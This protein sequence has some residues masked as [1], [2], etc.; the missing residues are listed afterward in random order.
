MADTTAPVFTTVP[1]E[2]ASAHGAVVDFDPPNATDVVDGL[3][4][5]ECIPPSGTVFVIGHSEVVCSAAD[6]AGNRAAVQFHVTVEDTTPPVFGNPP[7]TLIVEATGRD[8]ASVSFDVPVAND[9]V[10]PHPD[11][12]CDPNPDSGWQGACSNW[13]AARM[14]KGE[15]CACSISTGG[16][17]GSAGKSK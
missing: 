2:A 11:V 17:S 15:A 12:V 14:A 5:V 4:Q 7:Q 16:P 8:G 1:V 6:G 13:C 9:L 10:D 3:Q